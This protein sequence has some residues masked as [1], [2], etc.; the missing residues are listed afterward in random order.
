MGDGGFVTEVITLVFFFFLSYTVAKD[1]L[2][3]VRTSPSLS[4]NC[5]TQVS[6]CLHKVIQRVT[7]LLTVFLGVIKFD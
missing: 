4:Q 5:H 6:V 1:V 7:L 3:T 2:R